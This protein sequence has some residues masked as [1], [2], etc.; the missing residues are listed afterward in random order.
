MMTP[1]L[2]MKR[3]SSFNLHLTADIDVSAYT[4]KY[5]FCDGIEAA[6]ESYVTRLYDNLEA[7]FAANEGLDAVLRYLNPGKRRL[8]VNRIH[9]DCCSIECTQGG[10]IYLTA[11]EDDSLI[12][13]FGHNNPGTGRIDLGYYDSLEAALFIGN[14]FKAYRMISKS[15]LSKVAETKKDLTYRT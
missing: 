15:F 6:W 10:R 4:S 2:Q 11:T 5:G 8:S 9:L 1:K 3:P 12:L 13:S 14:I 7:S